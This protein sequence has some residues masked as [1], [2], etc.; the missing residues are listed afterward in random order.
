MEGRGRGRAVGS[1]EDERVGL[2]SLRNATRNP[3][4]NRIINRVSEANGADGLNS[5][6]NNPDEASSTDPADPVVAGPAVADPAAAARASDAPTNNVTVEASPNGDTAVA[7]VAANPNAATAAPIT[8]ATPVPAVPVAT[9][10]GNIANAAGLT[11]AAADKSAG[12]ACMSPPMVPIS[13]PNPS[14]GSVGKVGSA[15]L[16]QNR[17]D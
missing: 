5:N 15:P 6:S 12:P 16:P 9:S 7:S 14:P 13:T 4:S 10:A 17:A 3:S 8:A 11:A 2:S 1:Q